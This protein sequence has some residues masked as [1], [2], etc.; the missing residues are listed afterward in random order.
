MTTKY[1]ADIQS[2]QDSI[3]EDGI[4]VTYGFLEPEFRQQT[5]DDTRIE[6]TVEVNVVFRTAFNRRQ[7]G[8]FMP[9]NELTA[10]MG[11]VDFI[12]KVGD[13]LITPKGTRYPIDE[14]TIVAPD[15]EPI[16]YYL[17]LIDG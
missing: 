13:Y 9:R 6:S 14:I 17:G 3:R 4:S 7:A 1:L 2:A 11:A 16:L 8:T 15:G 12:P 5:T 10:L